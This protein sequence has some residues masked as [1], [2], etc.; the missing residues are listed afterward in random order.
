MVVNFT[1]IQEVLTAVVGLV[2][3]LI[4]LITGIFPAIVAMAVIAFI[5]GFLGKILGMMDRVF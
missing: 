5:G 4:D 1:P 2:P 3:S